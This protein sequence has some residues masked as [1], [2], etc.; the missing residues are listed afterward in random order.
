M[1]LANLS[2]VMAP[3]YL[4]WLRCH[5]QA[6]FRACNQVLYHHKNPVQTLNFREC[7]NSI[8]G[9]GKSQKNSKHCNSCDS[10]PNF[11]CKIL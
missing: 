1:I 11:R 2:P 3:V 8:R 9:L 5:A 10:E 6:N 7:N 4:E